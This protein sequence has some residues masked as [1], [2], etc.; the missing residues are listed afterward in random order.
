[1]EFLKSVFG[2]G[3]LTFDEFAAVAAEA[4]LKLADLA[5]GGYVDKRKLTELTDTNN[6]LKSTL[7]NCQAELDEFKK[8]DVES[9]QGRLSEM[10]ELIKSK[11]EEDHLREADLALTQMIVDC[12]GDKC[13]TSEYLK[14][15]VIAD[16][17]AGLA[18]DNSKSVQQ[19]FNEVAGD[20]AGFFMS[21]NPAPAMD[22]IGSIDTAYLNR[23]T[24]RNAMGLKSKE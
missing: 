1:M 19:I 15:K 9:L 22:G 10:E 16:V 5:A 14:N 17:K 24:L 20:K 11:S 7:S 21:F 13:F 3:S 2:E 12:I 8:L 6:A 4:G 18:R 23:N